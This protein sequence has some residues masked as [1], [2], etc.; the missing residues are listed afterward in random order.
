MVQYWKCMTQHC[1]FSHWR[2]SPIHY[3]ITFHQQYPRSVSLAESHTWSWQ[4]VSHIHTK[5]PCNF[6]LNLSPLQSS[7]RVHF[8]TGGRLLYPG[9]VGERFFIKWIDNGWSKSGSCTLSIWDHNSGTKLP[10]PL[11]LPTIKL[12]SITVWPACSQML[13]LQAFSYKLMLKPEWLM[14]LA[15]QLYLWPDCIKLALSI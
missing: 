10:F 2:S 1:A 14:R 9:S 7:Y 4:S 13:S 5:K 3:F 11:L 8:F 15:K 12:H 6:I